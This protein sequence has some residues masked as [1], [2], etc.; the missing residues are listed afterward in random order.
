M[1]V[2][3]IM[4]FCLTGTAVI[5]SVVNWIILLSLSSKIN[6]LEQ[7]IDKK[8]Q[9]FDNLKKEKSSLTKP[10]VHV[11]DTPA[12]D[13]TDPITSDEP[14]QV[15][16]N[17]GGSFE[18]AE[19]PVLKPAEY[20]PSPNEIYAAAPEITESQVHTC[21]I[22]LNESIPLSSPNQ[23]GMENEV[24]ATISE[25]PEFENHLP[26]TTFPL[27][28]ESAK[29]AD[30]NNL[31]RNIYSLLQSNIQSE[32]GIDFTGINYLYDKEL[33][34]LLKITKIIISAGSKVHFLNCDTE[35]VSI[36]SKYSE[37]SF[38]IKKNL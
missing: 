5:F 7:E 35:L 16:R 26:L 33:G 29:D 2:L 12:V 14:I 27:Y 22:N 28:S 34:Y 36:M 6:E 24:M 37:L 1:S 17:V 4:A 15:M 25:Q 11:V 13:V 9:E 18:R 23:I 38:Y 10:L 8:A 32:I 3:V 30:F 21:D 19:K 20:K 31:W